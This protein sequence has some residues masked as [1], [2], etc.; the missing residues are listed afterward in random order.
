MRENKYGERVFSFITLFDAG[1][2][3][4]S[5]GDRQVGFGRIVVSTNETPVVLVN[6]E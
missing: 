1:E 6:M 5:T 4:P 3:H 2:A